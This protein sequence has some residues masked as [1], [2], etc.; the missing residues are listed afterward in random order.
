ME[1]DAMCYSRSWFDDAERKA[2]EAAAKA[3]ER[4]RSDTVRSLL[5]DAGKQAEAAKAR[6]A[7]N[8]EAAPAK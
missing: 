1:E 5:S 2:R 3:A 8:S 4:K 6:A 7:A